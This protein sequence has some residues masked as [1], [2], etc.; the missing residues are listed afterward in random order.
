MKKESG[1]GPEETESPDG[2]GKQTHDQHFTT[3]LK[4]TRTSRCLED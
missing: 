1:D 3:L 4:K 2:E